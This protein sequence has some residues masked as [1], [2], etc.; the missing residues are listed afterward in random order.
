MVEKPMYSRP[1]ITEGVFKTLNT[2][3]G[4]LG[5]VMYIR[6]PALEQSTFEYV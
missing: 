1:V 2:I 5:S 6:N 3:T 4:R